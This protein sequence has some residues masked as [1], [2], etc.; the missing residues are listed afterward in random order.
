MKKK[1][2][3][4]YELNDIVSITGRSIHTI[5][6]DYAAGRFDSNNFESVILYILRVG[7][8]VEKREVES[9]E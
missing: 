2:R 8:N 5:R 6:D 3:W 1:R 9:Y 4:T 7:V